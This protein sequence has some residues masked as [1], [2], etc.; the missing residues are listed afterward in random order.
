VPTEK[1]L[2]ALQVQERVILSDGEKVKG[3]FLVVRCIL[4]D[5]EEFEETVNVQGSLHFS[6]K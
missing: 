5:K 1:I 6:F 3:S 4:K 2:G